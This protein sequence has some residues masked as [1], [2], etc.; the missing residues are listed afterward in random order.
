MN[1]TSLFLAIATV[2]LGSTWLFAN[3]E[4]ELSPEQAKEL[5][6]EAYIYGYPLVSMDI[7]KQVMS[8][9]RAPIGQF[10]N[11]R[12]FPTTDYKEVTAPNVDTLYSTAWLDL[13]KEPWVLHVPNEDGRYYLM[14]MLDG[15]TD[16]FADPGTRTTGTKTADFVITGPNWAGKLPDGLKTELKITLTMD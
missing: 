5:A 3:Q 16:V 8:Q 9:T 10:A 2:A 7:T 15:W 4:T 13:A 12:T 14:P 6:I 1:K 11:S